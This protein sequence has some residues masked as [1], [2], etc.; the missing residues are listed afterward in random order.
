MVIGLSDIVAKNGE[1]LIEMKPL[2]RRFEQVE[3]IDGEGRGIFYFHQPGDYVY[4]FLLTKKTIETVHYPFRTYLIRAFEAQQDGV[5]LY[6]S[7]SEDGE[8]IEIPANIMIR[9]IVED[10]ELIGSL[11]KIVFIGKKGQKKYYRV[12]KDTGTFYKNEVEKYGRARKK[13]KVKRQQ[14]TAAS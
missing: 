7:E 5:P 8:I 3:K 12:F 13:R 6:I 10:N 4:G 2:P 1:N 11:V 14:R 9:R